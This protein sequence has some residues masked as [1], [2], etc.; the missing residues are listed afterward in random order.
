MTLLV[1]LWGERLHHWL[2][3]SCVLK[4]HV[5]FV[6]K[7]SFKMWWTTYLTK[8]YHTPDD[9][10]FCFSYV[11]IISLFHFWISFVCF[12]L[13]FSVLFVP[14]KKSHDLKFSTY[15]QQETYYFLYW[16]FWQHKIS[17]FTQ[18]SLLNLEHLHFFYNSHMRAVRKV[19]GHL[20]Y[21]ENQLWGL[22][23]TWQPVRGD[24]TVHLWTVTLLWD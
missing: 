9:W 19:T 2:S 5:T 3:G 21:L 1:V 22:D 4:E 14:W 24:L 8:W 16:H 23:V 13:S 15:Y 18:V 7:G 6:I 17:S 20:E 11:V 10:N 12:S